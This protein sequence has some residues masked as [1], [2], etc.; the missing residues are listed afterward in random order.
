M[1]QSIQQLNEN[2]Q[3]T[4]RLQQVKSSQAQHMFQRQTNHQNG[5]GVQ[6]VGK[7]YGELTGYLEESH[8]YYGGHPHSIHAGPIRFFDDLKPDLLKEIASMDKRNIE[9][10]LNLFRLYQKNQGCKGGQKPT[11]N[12]GNN[13]G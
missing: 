9:V 3:H 5:S 4:S 11:V 2:C 7:Q 1:E 6:Q 12:N 8:D 10:L 13:Y